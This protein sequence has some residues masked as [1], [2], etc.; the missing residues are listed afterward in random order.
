MNKR[1][2]CIA[3]GSGLIFLSVV[4]GAMASIAWFTVTNGFGVGITG[5]FVEEYFH[6]GD[7]TSAHP[8]V[9]TRPIHYYHLVELVL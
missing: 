3:L 4:S 6:T 5:S 9:I 7:G 2:L 8:F 1:K